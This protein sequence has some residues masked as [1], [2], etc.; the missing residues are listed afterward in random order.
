M[1][2]PRPIDD[3]YDAARALAD[4][5]TSSAAL[6]EIAHSY[7]ELAD[8]VAKH[9][10]VPPDLRAWLAAQSSQASARGTDRPDTWGGATA[11]ASNLSTAYAPLVHHVSTA[12]TA[13][14]SRTR[15]VVAW[16]LI[17]AAAVTALVLAVLHGGDDG[18]GAASPPANA[19]TTVDAGVA[20]SATSAPPAT[21]SSAPIEASEAP[22][23]PTPTPTP[24]ATPTPT[25]T[26]TPSS[27]DERTL[28]DEI[29]CGLTGA[30][31]AVGYTDRF[32][33]II[34]DDADGLVYIGT[35][36]ETGSNIR[37]PASAAGTGYA[38]SNGA[39]AYSLTPARLEVT[40]DS[41]VLVD[42]AIYSWQ[43][44]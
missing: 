12:A 16:V 18:D 30:V 34:C 2:V 5:T 4:P 1:T 14:R 33:A 26:P 29:F 28:N 35:N 37:L 21:T 9:P 6:T 40:G 20:P 41:G 43:T 3:V 10:H 13:G 36:L 32:E 7:P 8:S 44:W 22:P 19:P 42:E 17:G 24:T 39:V 31:V 15:P 25:P 23:T 38:A 11:S 27:A